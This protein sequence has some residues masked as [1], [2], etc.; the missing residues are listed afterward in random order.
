MILIRSLADIPKA[1]LPTRLTVAV[2]RQM[3]RIL[4]TYADYKPDD[5]GYLSLV[6]HRDTDAK[7]IEQLGW[8]W[9]ANCFEGVLYDA[10]AQLFIVTILR[11]NQFVETVLIP[12]EPWL[13]PAIRQRLTT[14]E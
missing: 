7:L 10:T 8:K 9:R 14:A 5:D 1:R 11:N 6:T 3:T 2:T 13:D 12:D 4:N